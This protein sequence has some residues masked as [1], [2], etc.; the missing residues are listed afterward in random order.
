M[1]GFHTPQNP[2]VKPTEDDVP[3]CGSTF[4]CRKRSI[5]LTGGHRTQD[6]SIQF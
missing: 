3:R 1:I 6:L 2:R 4:C 5:S